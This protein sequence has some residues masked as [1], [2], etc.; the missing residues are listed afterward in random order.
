MFCYSLSLSLSLSFL[1]FCSDRKWSGP[2][3]SPGGGEEAHGLWCPF[4]GGSGEL[5]H[6]K[7]HRVTLVC[8]LISFFFRLRTKTRE[9][10][11]VTFQTNPNRLRNT[12]NKTFNTPW[13]V[14]YKKNNVSLTL[15]S[16]TLPQNH[17][18]RVLNILLKGIIVCQRNMMQL[19]KKS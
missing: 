11:F 9:V 12:H 8:F 17:V 13:P 6:T 10:V 15:F 7:F 4:S 16:Y 14:T 5:C 2:R 1:D 19:R 3:A 18:Y